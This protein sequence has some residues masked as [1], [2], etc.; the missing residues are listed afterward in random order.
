M[1][2]GI[3]TPSKFVPVPRAIGKPPVSFVYPPILGKLPFM[4]MMYFSGLDFSRATS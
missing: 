2:P 3:N 4:G 1:T